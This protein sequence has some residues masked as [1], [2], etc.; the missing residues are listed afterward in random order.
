MKED[1]LANKVYS[2]VRKKILSSQLVGGARL[3]ESVWADKLA[4][5]RVAVREAFMRLAGESLVEFGE[6]GGCFVKKMTA[7]DV[8]DIR[9]LRELLEV[10]A[11]KILFAK[12]DKEVIRDLELICNDFSEMVSKGYYGGACEAD[13]RFHERIIEGTEN[14]RLIAIYKNSNIP[15]FHMKLGAI[16]GQ[17]EDYKDTEEEHKSLVQA[18][19][20]DDWEKA[21]DT[22]VNHLDRGE[23]EALELI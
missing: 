16:M 1:S 19:K 3:V 17:M 21:Y 13:V 18:L 20:A 15:L 7:E 9:E 8:K 10:G 11:L 22:L 14:A 23:H 6:K 12:K 5:S 2:E 4:V